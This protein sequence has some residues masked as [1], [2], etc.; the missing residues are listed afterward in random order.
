MSKIYKVKVKDA[1]PEVGIF[2][3]VENV[4]LKD[5]EATQS[6]KIAGNVFSGEHLHLHANDVKRLVAASNNISKETKSRFASNPSEYLNW[7]RG[8]VDYDID[9][10]H[11]TIMASKKFFSSETIERVTREFHLPPCASGKIELI[12]DEGHYGY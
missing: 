4:F 11:W 10:G 6:L 9:T 7:P 12:A 3:I 1:R 2:E 8:R 5:T